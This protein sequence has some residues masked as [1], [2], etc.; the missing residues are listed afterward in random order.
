M[1]IAL[2]VRPLIDSHNTGVG[3][4]T[5]YCVTRLIAAHPEDEFLLEYFDRD[6][7]RKMLAGFMQ[8]N[9]V[10]VTSRFPRKLY[11]LIAAFLPLPYC[12]FIKSNADVS[13]FFNYIIPPFVRGR[14]IVTIHD[15]AF[16][17]Y[18][19]T[20]RVQSKI[21]L[22]LSLRR[23][24][25]RADRIITVSEF[26]KAEILHY[27]PEAADKIRVIYHGVDHTLF[28]EAAAKSAREAARQK[29]AGSKD[30]ILYLG[31]VEPRKNIK[32]LISA[33]AAVK[34]RRRDFPQLL[35]AGSLGW[36][37]GAILQA[38]KDLRLEKSV[39]FTGYVE[40][41]E[42]PGLL[43]GARFFCFP[44]LYE[45]FGMPVI[46]ALACGAPVLTSD[47]SALREIAGDAA[48]LVDPFST[49]K[50]AAGMEQLYLD[51]RLC[52]EL[53]KKAVERAK[54]FTWEKTAAATYAL[55]QEITGR[56]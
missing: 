34:S 2:E 22:E 47:N 53:R 9:T 26:S 32:R 56:A 24:V 48:F 7:V 31:T 11:R 35:I 55:Y 1:K 27:Y 30:Y 43:G 51:A 38:V 41:D 20:V 8:K 39:V 29:Y 25:K 4:S 50:M 42:M 14:K 40:R 37:Y 18:P 12:W 33:Y 16:K 46:E 36:K 23:V 49:D 13:H 3:Y 17:R 21:L 54:R 10:P 19:E 52:A 6:A 44:S 15:M 28:N 45:G 5:E